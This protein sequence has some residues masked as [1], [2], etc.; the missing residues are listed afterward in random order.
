MRRAFISRALQA[1]GSTY[2]SESAES[3]PISFE[4]S[5]T[6]AMLGVSD[7]NIGNWYG[8]CRCAAQERE[9]LQQG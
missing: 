7:H 2:R 6:I 8:A 1:T 5:D 4:V 3:V 9:P